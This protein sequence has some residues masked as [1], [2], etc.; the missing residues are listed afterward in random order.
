MATMPWEFRLRM[1]LPAIPANTEWLLQP[2]IS[3]ASSTARWMACT[4]DSILTT[5]PFFMPL[6]RCM[7]VPI[8][9]RPPSAPATPTMHTTLEVPISSPTIICSLLALAIYLPQS[10]LAARFRR[11]FNRGFPAH[12]NTVAVADIHL[13]HTFH[14]LLQRLVPNLHKALQLAGHRLLADQQGQ[15]G[16]EPE[17]PVAPR[18]QLAGLHL[19]PQGLQNLGKVPVLLHH[20]PLHAFRPVQQGQGLRE[21]DIADIQDLALVVEESPLTPAGDGHLLLNGNH[22]LVRPLAPGGSRGHPGVG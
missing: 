1:W 20:P 4:V 19:E 17:V 21:L 12:C 14:A 2:A 15:A 13:F 22:H 3:S 11:G 5:T 6:E 9:S 10:A 16:L 18:R 7:P 8:I